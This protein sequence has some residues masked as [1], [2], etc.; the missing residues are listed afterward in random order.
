MDKKIGDY[1]IKELEKI[2]HGPVADL[3]KDDNKVGLFAWNFSLYFTWLFLHTRITPNQITFLSTVG[4]YIGIVLLMLNDYLL[5]V[6]GS[7][8]IFFSII[9]DGCDGEVARFRKKT[10]NL[11]A[12]YVEPVSHDIQYGFAFLM[13]SIGLVM[14]GFPSYYYILGSIAGLTKISTRLLQLRF[15]GLLR[16]KMSDEEIADT[17]KSLKSKSIFIKIAYRINKNFFNYAGFFIVIF[18]GSLIGRINLSLWFSSIGYFLMWIAIFG[19][20]IYQIYH[21]KLN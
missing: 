5:G 21:H 15:S 10:S 2:C 19:K 14:H 4:F 7:L 18:I 1:T 9:L 12:F 11:G 8:V 17:H 16:L 13:I 3:K 20:Q 6:I